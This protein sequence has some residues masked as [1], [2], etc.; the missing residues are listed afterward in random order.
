MPGQISNS[1]YGKFPLFFM[2]PW[3]AGRFA[4][5]GVHTQNTPH[6]LRRTLM[7][8]VLIGTSGRLADALWY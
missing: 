5:G 4:I 3:Q 2:L 8:P 6:R 1:R 7:Q